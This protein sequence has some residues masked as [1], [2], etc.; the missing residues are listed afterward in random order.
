MAKTLLLIDANSLIHRAYHALPPLTDSKGEPAGA[1]YGLANSLLKVLREIGPEYVVA[2]FDRP[3]PTFRK[4]MFKDYKAHRPPA[5]RELIHQIK[6]SYEVMEKFNIRIVEL[7]GFEADDIIGT[8]V[9]RFSGNDMKTVILTGDLDTLQLVKNGE[10]EVRTP[11]KGAGEM[12]VYDE[13][14]VEERFGVRPGQLADFK[15]LVGDSSD[16]IPGVPGI[17]EKTAAEIIREYSNLE[18]A[19]K[20]MD[21]ESKV[22]KKLMPAKEKALFSRKLAEIELNAPVSTELRDLKHTSPNK[23]NLLGYFKELGFVSLVNRFNGFKSGKEEPKKALG[24]IFIPDAEYILKNRKEVSSGKTKVALGWKSIMKKVVKKNIEIRPPIFDLVIAKWLLYPDT[25]TDIKTFLK[26]HKIEN[27]NSEKKKVLGIAS[28]L[29]EEIEKNGLGKVFWEIE[30]PI[31]PILARMEIWG[32]GVNRKKLSVL[33]KSIQKEIDGLKSGIYKLSGESFNINSPKQVAAVLAKKF[34]IKT[35]KKT[36][37]GQ[38]KTG[39]NALKEFKKDSP[40]IGLISEYRE[41]F[42]IKT[43][44]VDALM[45]RIEKDGVVRAK[46]IQTGTAT[47][48]LTS[49]EPNLQNIPQE[50]KWSKELR[51]A[52]EAR[53]G[54]SFI[55]L[56]YSQLELRLLAH[57]SGDKKLKKAFKEDKDVHR[58]TASQILGIPLSQVSPELRR[59]GKTLNFGIVYGMGARAL[60]ATSGISP[61]KSKIFI[62]KYFENFSGIREWQEKIKEQVRSSGY[63]ENLNGRKRWFTDGLKSYGSLRGDF[64]RAAINMPIQSLEADIIKI[65]M[66]KSFELL[67]KNGWL[68]DKARIILSIHDELLFEVRD[69]ILNKVA[70]MLKEEA[71]NSYPISIPLKVEIKT[72]KNWG[73]LEKSENEK[74]P[75]LL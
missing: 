59:L 30:M 25:K 45:N 47:G 33:N 11:Q 24:G 68:G 52:F 21:P 72:G 38:N 75:S 65:A 60:A 43:G 12:K 10:V 13:K 18:N 8:L 62:E 56:D 42:K 32:I 48:R 19:L 51:N 40:V 15:G 36:S 2:A 28:D 16:N 26:D 57:V 54:M 44:F 66:I 34:G 17:G 50:S 6:K 67:K 7:A 39:K 27:L 64:E 20:K 53:K 61:E 63:A 14:A 35:K 4:K 1:I 49:A 41:N 22:G 55:S 46:F 71:E 58:I 23:E 69:D 3:E 9:K 29:N 5:D 37:S 70:G 73:S 74:N 31:V